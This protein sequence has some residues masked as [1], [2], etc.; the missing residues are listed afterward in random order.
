MRS[1]GN[2]NRRKRRKQRWALPGG[3][4]ARWDWWRAFVK[5]EGRQVFTEPS[6]R[7][8]RSQ[9]REGREGKASEAGVEQKVAKENEDGGAAWRWRCGVSLG[10][11][12]GGR[13]GA[14]TAERRSLRGRW[15]RGGLGERV[16]P[17]GLCVVSGDERRR[18]C[19][20]RRPGEEKRAVAGLTPRPSP[21]GSSK[22]R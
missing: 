9:R 20:E 10:A 12:R 17:P 11:C 15:S 6:L 2:L 16:P 22:S 7:D 18:Q 3:G 14:G 8:R 5:A 4:G 21:P 13:N 1:D 19:E